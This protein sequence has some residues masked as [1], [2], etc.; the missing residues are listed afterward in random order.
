MNSLDCSHKR[1]QGCVVDVE[2]NLNCDAKQPKLQSCVVG[3]LNRRIAAA[4]AGYDG[5][6][7]EEAV[8]LNL[9][10]SLNAGKDDDPH[11]PNRRE[12]KSW[13]DWNLSWARRNGCCLPDDEEASSHLG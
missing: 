2:S 13:P 1:R 9:Q 4:A 10:K 7:S 6:D 12:S 8:R 11:R 3:G 5:V